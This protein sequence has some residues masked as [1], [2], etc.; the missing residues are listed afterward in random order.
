MDFRYLFNPIT[1]GAMQLKNR[2]AMPCINHSFSADG[3]TNDRLVAYYAAR[4]KGGAGMLTV[5]GCAVHELGRSFQVMCIYDDR[6]SAGLQK[7]T[8][9]VHEHGAKV[10][11]QLYHAGGYAKSRDIGAQAV[12]PSA[13]SSKYTHETPREMTLEDIE[14]AKQSFIAAAQRAKRVGFD[15]VELIASAGY[16]IAEF[17]SPYTNLRTDDYGGAWEN[18]SLFLIELI[19]GIKAA[20][21]ND[22]PVLV[23]LSGNDF[24]AS[25][26]T[27]SNAVKVAQVLEKH[28][29]DAINITGGWHESQIPQTTGELPAGGY[30]YLAA[31]VKKAVKIPVIASNRINDPVEAERIIA[32][33]LADMVNMGRG[34]LADPELPNK[35]QAGELQ[36]IRRCIACGQGCYDRRFS[37]K[38]VCCMINYEAGRELTVSR[39]KAVR[40]KNILVVGGGAAGMEFAIQAAERR[41]NVTLWEK[42]PCLGGQ[43]C[44]AAKA[45]GKH[46][47]RYLLQYQSARLKKL[48][49]TVVLNQE[50][51]AENILAFQPDAVVLASGSEPVPAPFPVA[52]GCHIVQANDVLAGRV[53][54]GQKVVIVGGGA[55]GCETAVLLAD[56]GTL[57]A[58]Q[59][60]FLM[61]HRAE[62][63]ELIHQLLEASNRSVSIVEMTKAVGTDI[64]ISTR[65]IVKKHMKQF[66]IA[67]LTE[68]TVTEVTNQGVKIQSGDGESRDLPADTVVLAIGSRSRDNLSGQLTGLVDEVYVIGDAVSPGKIS[69]C[70]ISAAEL[71]LRI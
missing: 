34:L 27:G 62:S 29:A 59:T 4:A 14:I 71:G 1:I 57:S 13:V 32:V 46:D 20:A 54:P 25:G 51:T 11:A 50:A 18:R 45:V 15:G 35:A 6:F 66:G 24:I 10:V 12:A 9:A 58:E 7:L 69:H 60:K 28:G 47:F 52:A 48:A 31:A 8:A 41:H 55:V 33:G 68:T 44:Y 64:G 53:I 40:S 30:S 19:T 36:S 70:I 39:Q 63:D 23:R 22:F 37:G 61:R 5:G 17:L 38:D 3:T 56:E 67:C 26:N 16:L 43:L 65:W 49:V 42:E 2:I 21:G